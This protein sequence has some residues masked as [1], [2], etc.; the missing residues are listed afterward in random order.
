MNSEMI[1]EPTNGSFGV[2]FEK[3]DMLLR[4]PAQLYESV[5]YLIIFVI[6]WVLFKKLKEKKDGFVFG[7]FLVLLFSARFFI[8]FFKMNQVDFEKTL[9]LNMGQLL[10][11]PFILSG[12]VLMVV[13]RKQK[14]INS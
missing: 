4:H 12:I 13:K 3:E 6:L 14:E 11:L 8:E 9:F 7:L 2:I 10:S 5:A 1:G